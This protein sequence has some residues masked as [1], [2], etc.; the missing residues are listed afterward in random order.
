VPGRSLRCAVALFSLCRVGCW[1]GS[2]GADRVNLAALP[3]ATGPRQLTAAVT[4]SGRR[5]NVFSH[6]PGLAVSDYRPV[7]HRPYR[8]VHIATRLTS[9]HWTSSR[10]A[11]FHLNR[12][13]VSA[14]RNPVRRGCDQSEQSTYRSRCLVLSEHSLPLGYKKTALSQR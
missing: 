11:P 14:L 4:V 12:V 3:V 5:H 13:A 9:S 1:R 8:T 2:S 10:L 7:D 6:V